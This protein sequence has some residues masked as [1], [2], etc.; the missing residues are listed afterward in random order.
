M[1]MFSVKP[2]GSRRSCD[3]G[4]R[5]ARR[6][7]RQLRT[8]SLGVNARKLIHLPGGSGAWSGSWILYLHRFLHRVQGWGSDG[9]SSRVCRPEVRAEQRCRCGIELGGRLRG[10]VEPLRFTSPHGEVASEGLVPVLRDEVQG[11]FVSQERG[12]A[13]PTPSRAIDWPCP[14]W[15]TRKRGRRPASRAGSVPPVDRRRARR[16]RRPPGCRTHRTRTDLRPDRNER[17]PAIDPQDGSLW[18]SV[19]G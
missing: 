7:V 5:T 4:R 2:A 16:R 13:P 12:E 3:G 19:H 6:D 8:G 9:G 18:F 14:E 10:A 17:F 15:S 1:V 11:G